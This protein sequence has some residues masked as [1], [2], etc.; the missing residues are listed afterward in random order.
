MFWRARRYYVLGYA[1]YGWKKIVLI[2]RIL[3]LYKG[4]GEK[5]IQVIGASTIIILN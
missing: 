5:L 4:D 1:E 2:V 3:A